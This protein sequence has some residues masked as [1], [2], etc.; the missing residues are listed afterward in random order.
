M[1]SGVVSPSWGWLVLDCWPTRVLVESHSL[2][3]LWQQHVSSWPNETPPP[4]HW[5]ARLS[6]LW[7]T[8]PVDYNEMN[9]AWRPAQSFQVTKDLER[10]HDRNNGS[11]MFFKCQRLFSHIMQRQLVWIGVFECGEPKYCIYFCF[12]HSF[13]I[14]L[15]LKKDYN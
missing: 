14:F 1:A 12:D 5:L 11:A 9:S 13:S 8:W 15:G 10:S 3:S 7:P 4:F 2:K 6:V